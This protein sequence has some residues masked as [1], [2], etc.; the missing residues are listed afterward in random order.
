MDEVI[1]EDNVFEGPVGDY[2]QILDE[3]P[4]LGLHAVGAAQ[5]VM[6]CFGVSVQV[7]DDGFG[8]AVSGCCEDIDRVMFTHLLEEVIT[9]RSDI[10]VETII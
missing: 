10:E 2:S 1:N 6:D 9:M 4:V 5:E 3:E 7:L 8:I